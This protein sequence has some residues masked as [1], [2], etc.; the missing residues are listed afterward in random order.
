MADSEYQKRQEGDKTI[1]DV[2]PASCPTN[3]SALY[4][5]VPIL[6]IMLVV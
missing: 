4:I 5:A 1:F 2:T 6:L 3:K